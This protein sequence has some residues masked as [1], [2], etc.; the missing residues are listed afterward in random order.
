LETHKFFSRNIK[1][2]NTTLFLKIVDVDLTKVPKKS[3]TQ[4]PNPCLIL[5]EFFHIFYKVLAKSLNLDISKTKFFNQ[6]LYFKMITFQV[7]D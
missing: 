4:N 5:S 6:D 2:S 1:Y 3:K 7:I